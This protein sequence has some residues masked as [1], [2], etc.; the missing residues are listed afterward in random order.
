MPSEF[1]QFAADPRA[2]ALGHLGESV[3][4]A[5]D[6][7]ADPATIQMIVGMEAGEPIQIDNERM[8]YRHRRVEGLLSDVMTAA[9]LSGNVPPRGTLFTINGETWTLHQAESIRAGW[10][11]LIVVIPQRQP[12]DGR[13]LPG[14]MR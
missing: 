8:L 10:A 1:E 11:V 14:V 6:A 2:H 3:A 7:D 9:G 5:A 13:Q 4:V 12:T